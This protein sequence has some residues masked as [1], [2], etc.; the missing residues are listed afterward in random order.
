MEAFAPRC[1]E[2]VTQSSARFP[3]RL[4]AALAA[5][6]AVQGCAAFPRLQAAPQ[7]WLLSARSDAADAR[8]TPRGGAVEVLQ[9]APATTQTPIPSAGASDEQIAALIAD[10]EIEA[11]LPPQPLPQFIDTVFGQL[12]QVP[13]VTGPGVSQRED[14]VAVRGP[15]AM[16]GRQFFA[17][18]QMTL[19]Q[20]GLAVQIDRGAVRIIADDVLSGRSPVFIRTRTLPDTPAYS[21]PVVQFFAV[22][23]LDVRSLVELMD[24]VYPNRGAVRF[25]VREDTNTLLIS[26]SAREVASAAAVISELDRPRFAA[27]EI[28]RVQ[29][30][31]MS[32]DELSDALS[33]TLTAEGYVV[34]GVRAPDGAGAITLLSIAQ[35]NQMLVF[36][37]DPALF[38]RALYWIQQLDQASALGDRDGVFIY[39]VR[40][41]SAEELGQLIA[42][43]SPGEAQGGGAVNNPPEVAVRRVDGQRIGQRFDPNQAGAATTLGAFTI[44]PAGNRILFR[45]SPSE[46]AHARSLLEQL[47]T[48]P[49]QVMV[50]LTV[51]EVTLT[52]E[53]RFGIEWFLQSSSNDGTLNLDTRGG[54]TRQ[55]GGLGATAT[56]IFSRGTV[57]AAL[58]AFASNQNL[59]ILST[60]RLVA[61]SGSSAE[62]L[63]GTDVPIIT[64]QR[65]ADTQA[66][67]DTDILQT[68]QYRQTGVIL[69]VR[70]IVYGDRIDIELYQEVSSQEPNDNSSIASPLILNR[71]VST[72]LSLQEGMTAVIGGMMQ[73]SY[74]RNQ[75]G[76]PALKDIP[77]LGSAF[78]SDT[79]DGS[80][81]ELVILVTPYIIRDADEMA[82]LA[83]LY[84]RSVNRQLSRRGPQVYTLYP[85]RPPFSAP[86]NHRARPR[87]DAEL[88]NGVASAVEVDAAPTESP[89]AEQAPEPQQLAPS[90]E[91]VT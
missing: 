58:N 79:V 40:N 85:W 74:S 48:P 49:L 36:A 59:N 31:Y 5:A 83:D 44:D 27:G 63:I 6:L 10:R 60:P 50:E 84:S 20:Y 67:G 28:A 89:P 91:P 64:S 57:Q 90:G 17:L 14:I 25:S 47:D 87:A 72:Q 80:K 81:V 73:D 15:N 61:R 39:D 24:Q 41:T 56:H 2:L 70:P 1:G 8:N 88:E 4:T 69:N 65:A 9:N 22:S 13:Y 19:E 45:G 43:V 11:T 16:S 35:A 30:T 78:R 7:R 71:S 62:I 37:N 77:F 23:S 29:P 68:V 46:F 66:G 34:T 76:V 53:T 54:S 18:V 38:A 42:Q 86:V 52:D 55:Q 75:R 12:L 21:R 3:L 51:A 32:V 82:D 26:G 33:R